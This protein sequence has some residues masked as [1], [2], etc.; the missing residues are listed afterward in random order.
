MRSAFSHLRRRKPS[1]DV[2]AATDGRAD[3]SVV[4]ELNQKRLRQDQKHCRKYCA[5]EPVFQR[6]RR[7]DDND[8]FGDRVVAAQL[9]PV[10]GEQQEW[11]FVVQRISFHIL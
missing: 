1:D 6:R 7:R 5:Q 11:R 9:Q 4:P 3:E 10:F 2:A 8:D